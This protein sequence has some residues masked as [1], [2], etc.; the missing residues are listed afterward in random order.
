MVYKENGATTS[1]ELKFLAAM[2]VG[3]D[4]ED[5]IAVTV[6]VITI[7]QHVHVTTDC[8]AIVGIDMLASGIREL[9]D[10]ERSDND[11]GS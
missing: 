2:Q 5:V 4:P 8:T 7:D 3:I 9:A 6:V 11:D 10:A 1:G